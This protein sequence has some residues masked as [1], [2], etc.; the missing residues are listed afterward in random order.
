M[1]LNHIEGINLLLIIITHYAIITMQWSHPSYTCKT[2]GPF[3][4]YIFQSNS[5]IFRFLPSNSIPPYYYVPNEMKRRE[6]SHRSGKNM[7][8]I[9]NSLVTSSNLFTELECRIAQRLHAINLWW[10]TCFT[11]LFTHS[12]DLNSQHRW[13]LTYHR[14]W[15]KQCKCIVKGGLHSNNK[16]IFCLT[17]VQS[18]STY[19]LWPFHYYRY[20]VII[21]N[22][23]TY[24]D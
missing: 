20:E 13:F 7:H 22:L 6:K 16:F 18:T 14:T 24:F 2:K 3:Y 15:H 11:I 4:Y 12:L 21:I 5:N 10:S 17:F 19:L 23:I 1:L 8:L 9:M